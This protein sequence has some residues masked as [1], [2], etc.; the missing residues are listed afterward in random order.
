MF[1]TFSSV[2]APVSGAAWA[3]GVAGGTLV[4]SK[5]LSAPAGEEKHSGIM[6][7]FHVYMF[8]PCH[9]IDFIQSHSRKKTALLGVKYKRN[10][11]GHNLRA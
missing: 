10:L 6:Y 2:F 11:T 9:V 7:I 8:W 1:T 5:S 4:L 3:S